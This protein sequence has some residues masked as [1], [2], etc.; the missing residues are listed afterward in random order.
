METTMKL[1]L[2]SRELTDDSRGYAQ[3][4]TVSRQKTIRT[5]DAALLLCDVWDNHPYRGAR[6]RLEAMLPKINHVAR[7]ARDMGVSIVHAPSE[8]MGFYS[9]S[10]ARQ[11]I[12]QMPRREPRERIVKR[13]PPLPYEAKKGGSDTG[14]PKAFRNWTRQHP[15]IIVDEERDVISD[16]GVEVYSYMQQ[17]GI[18][19]LLI[20][21][22]HTNKCVLNR[23]FGVKQMVRWGLS[24]YLVRDLT[25][26]I[27]SPALPP[28]VSHARGTA[29]A[30]EYIEKFWCAS[31]R[32]SDITWSRADGCLDAAKARPLR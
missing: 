6:E 8:T 24:V 30:V 23:S 17:A 19:S 10:P 32:S 13:D 18:R 2:R 1:R 31:I 20:L 14:E 12:L 11:R 28:Y 26:A 9:N 5:S 15:D 21:G 29:L 25:D 3:W 7:T 22:V 4:K 16:D 27:Y